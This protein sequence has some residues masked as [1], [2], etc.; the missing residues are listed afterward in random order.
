MMNCTLAFNNALNDEGK[1]FED[2]FF[3]SLW[4]SST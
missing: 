2:F 1:V 3:F 4:L